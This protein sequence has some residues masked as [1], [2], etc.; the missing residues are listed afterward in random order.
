MAEQLQHNALKDFVDQSI[1]PRKEIEQD[2]DLRVDVFGNF[3]VY[4]YPIVTSF[5]QPPICGMLP[6]FAPHDMHKYI[7]AI[8]DFELNINADSLNLPGMTYAIHRAMPM[9]SQKTISM[10]W[11]NTKTPYIETIFVPWMQD[12]TINGAFPLVKCDLAITFPK[13]EE[14]NSTQIV[15]WYYGVRPIEVDMHKMT[16]EPLQDFYR[17]VTFDFDYFYCSPEGI[18]AEKRLPEKS[19]S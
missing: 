5:A 2:K 6:F 19:L 1:R 12:N 17:K 13:L 9:N 3:E 16:N 18:T 8:N 11:L 4:F 14:S 15:Y 7:K 10:T